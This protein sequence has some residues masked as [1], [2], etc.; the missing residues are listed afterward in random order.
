MHKKE[1]SDIRN[2]N[3]KEIMEKYYWRVEKGL[4]Q[5]VQ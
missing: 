2:L 5:D 1:D 4:E 3:R